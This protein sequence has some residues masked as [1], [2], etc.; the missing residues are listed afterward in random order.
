MSPRRLAA[1]VLLFWSIGCSRERSAVPLVSRTP[2][3]NTASPPGVDAADR[4]QALVRVVNALPELAVV[5]LLGADYALFP[6]VP[7]GSVTGYRSVEAD[8]I[9]LRLRTGADSAVVAEAGQKLTDGYRYTIVAIPSTEGSGFR[10]RSEE[11][12]VGKGV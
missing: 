4:D 5:S 11:R 2:S 8:A 1:V 7:A 10:L 9:T 6:T 12:R 3:G